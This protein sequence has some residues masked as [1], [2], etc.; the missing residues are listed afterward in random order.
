MSVD[1]YKTVRTWLQRILGYC[2]HCRRFFRYD[3]KTTHRITT[4]ANE[5]DNYITACEDCRKADNK[6]YSK[7]WDDYFKR[8][9]I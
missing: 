6:F 9:N 2:P 5:S 3:V 7:L 8:L 4:Y 1:K